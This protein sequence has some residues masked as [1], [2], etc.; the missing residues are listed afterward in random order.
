MSVDGQEHAHLL[1]NDT[2][3]IT[4]SPRS[5]RLVLVPGYSYFDLLRRKLH[6]RGSSL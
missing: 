3:T 4:R 6:W 5:A 2:I 1:Q